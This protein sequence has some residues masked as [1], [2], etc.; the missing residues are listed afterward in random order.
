MVA[1]SPSPSV[2][3]GRA[4]RDIV[5]YERSNLAANVMC[6]CSPS[7]TESTAYVAILR[8]VN[9]GGTGTLAHERAEIHLC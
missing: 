5:V 1:E 2:Y 6:C 3:G 7:D 4:R 8:A 9:V